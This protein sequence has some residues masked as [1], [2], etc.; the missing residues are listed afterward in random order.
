MASL[1]PVT[2]EEVAEYFSKEEW[3]LL[4]PTQTALYKDIMQESYEIV[5]WRAGFL[6]SKPDVISR[7]EREEESWVHGLQGYEERRIPGDIHR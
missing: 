2:F 6:I 3:A 1:E 7:L 5:T 4:D